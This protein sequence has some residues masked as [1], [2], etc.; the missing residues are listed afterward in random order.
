M[1]LYKSVKDVN[2]ILS[3]LHECQVFFFFMKS[4]T[5]W[6]CPPL[7][8]NNTLEA[9]NSP[10]LTVVPDLHVLNT[11]FQLSLKLKSFSY[12]KWRKVNISSSFLFFFSLNKTIP[13][14]LSKFMLYL[15]PVCIHNVHS[16]YIC[17][18]SSTWSVLRSGP[19]KV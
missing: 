18:E 11:R 17:D 10:Q 12:T 2:N 8:R 7:Y 15:H 14:F 13:R 19:M 16:V 3:N 5:R 9:C 6:H 1:S 4:A